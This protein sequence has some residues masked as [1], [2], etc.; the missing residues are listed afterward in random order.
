MHRH[1]HQPDLAP[2]ARDQI[3]QCRNNDDWRND[4]S[5]AGSARRPCG[6]TTVANGARVNTKTMP[7]SLELREMI[8]VHAAY[9]SSSVSLI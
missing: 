4:P 8:V 5:G 7:S 6:T 2:P 1:L 3:T 9:T